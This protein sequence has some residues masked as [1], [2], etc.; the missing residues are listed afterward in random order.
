[1]NEP[2]ELKGITGLVGTRILMGPFER[3]IRAAKRRLLGRIRTL[4]G[5]AAGRLD[6]LEELEELE[7][8]M[9]AWL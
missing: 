4:Q 1:L 6:M 7:N 3:M 8:E 2:D 5:M 9:K